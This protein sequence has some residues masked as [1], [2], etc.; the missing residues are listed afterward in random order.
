MQQ[1]KH[2]DECHWM[3]NLETGS[4]KWLV[5]FLTLTHSNMNDNDTS[6]MDSVFAVLLYEDMN[7][8]AA[9]VVTSQVLLGKWHALIAQ[10][11]K[12]LWL[13]EK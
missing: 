8:T 7:F 13:K 11:Q 1:I 4:V 9:L 3:L 6:S 10:T 5:K 2:V 12:F